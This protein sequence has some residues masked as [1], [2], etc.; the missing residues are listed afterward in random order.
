MK[1][2]KIF[3][4]S[5]DKEGKPRINKWG[6]PYTIVNCYF[7]GG[8]K[9]Y[10]MFVNEGSKDSSV[11]QWKEGDDVEVVFE[12]RGDFWNFKLPEKSDLL[13]KRIDKL[14]TQAKWLYEKITA[15]EANLSKSGTDDQKQTENA[16]QGQIE[17]K[18]DP[19]DRP[20]EA[21]KNRKSESE[22]VI[23]NL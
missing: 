11:L 19:S 15:L 7:E 10:S 13:E 6:K 14:E 12:Q 17:G 4:N 16:S 9:K 3:F 2:T 23:D 21:L 18:K 5:T 8:E 22:R 1:I 20:W